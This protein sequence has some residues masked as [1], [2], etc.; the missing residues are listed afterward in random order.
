MREYIER[1]RAVRRKEAEAGAALAATPA[2]QRLPEVLAGLDALLVP[3][4]VGGGP[5]A[6]RRATPA[7][8][9]FCR[10]WT[11]LGVPAISV[12]GLT[13]PAGMPVGVQLVGLDEAAVLGAAAWVEAALA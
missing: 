5:A 12:P 13:G 11:L 10:A 4:A 7:T 3:A 8:R 2:A 6:R 1:G 9:C